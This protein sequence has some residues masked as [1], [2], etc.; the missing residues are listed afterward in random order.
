MYLG[1]RCNRWCTSGQCLQVICGNME[2]IHRYFCGVGFGCW[3]F[4]YYGGCCAKRQAFTERG[5]HLLH[6]AIHL[7]RQ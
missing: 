2:S 3:L 6:Q 1:G 4:S 7:A 5:V